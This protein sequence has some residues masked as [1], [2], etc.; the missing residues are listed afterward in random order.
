[1]S[2]FAGIVGPLLLG[3]FWSSGEGDPRRGILFIAVFFVVGAILLWR[4][5]VDAGRRAVQEEKSD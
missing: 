2:K 4:V 5:D 3:V 1:M